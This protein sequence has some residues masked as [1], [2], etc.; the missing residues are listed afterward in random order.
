MTQTPVLAIRAENSGRRRSFPCVG[1][2]SP[3]HRDAGIIRG[4]R[5]VV[6]RTDGS[7]VVERAAGACPVRSFADVE[8]AFPPAPDLSSMS[9]E[10]LRRIAGSN[11][12]TPGR[13]ALATGAVQGGMTYDQFF[14]SPGGPSGT[15]LLSDA[16]VG[17]TGARVRA[18]GRDFDDVD[19]AFSRPTPFRLPSDA[20][21]LSD[22]QFLGTPTPV[23]PDVARSAASGFRAAFNP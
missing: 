3:N 21:E 6:Y 20:D 18:P 15:H 7:S 4:N 22:E 10:A 5:W 1:R 23:G 16:D 11:G 12:T 17:L 19:K 2:R 14:G 13:G 9:D 8:K